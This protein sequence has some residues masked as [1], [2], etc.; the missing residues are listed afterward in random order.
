M[1]V[2][3]ELIESNTTYAA[4]FTKGHLPLPPAR[5]VAVLA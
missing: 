1:S 2:T 4:G 5:R 3:D